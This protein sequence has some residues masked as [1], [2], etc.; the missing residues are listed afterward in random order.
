MTQGNTEYSRGSL[1]IV[2]EMFKIGRAVD[3][4]EPVEQRITSILMEARKKGQFRQTALTILEMMKAFR[5]EDDFCK[6][7]KTLEGDAL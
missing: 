1:P 2:L 3:L 5:T 4:S 7:L 6:K